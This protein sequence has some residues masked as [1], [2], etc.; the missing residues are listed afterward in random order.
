MRR[1]FSRTRLCRALT[2]DY[3]GAGPSDGPPLRLD[4]Y[5]RV[6]DIVAAVTYFSVQP[7]VG[8]ERIGAFG[9]RFSRS[10]A[11]WCAAFDRRVASVLTVVRVGDGPRGSGVFVAR[12]NGGTFSGAEPRIACDSS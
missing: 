5:G 9:W 10:V 8:P 11:I 4:P 1:A 6:A 3:K 12:T 2:F 7:G